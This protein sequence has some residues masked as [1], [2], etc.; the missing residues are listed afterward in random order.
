MTPHA[1]IHRRDG[2]KDVS[3]FVNF[4]VQ[5]M[6]DAWIGARCRLTQIQFISIGDSFA[7]RHEKDS[8][9]VDAL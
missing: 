4:Q 8:M 6:R 9:A 1:G 2:F 3:M 5:R 7:L